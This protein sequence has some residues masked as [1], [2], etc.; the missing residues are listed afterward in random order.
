VASGD[1]GN[2]VA[3]ASAVRSLEFAAQDE[4]TIMA[5]AELTSYLL[6]VTTKTSVLPQYHAEIESSEEYPLRF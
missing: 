4:Q 3:S 2:H 1:A 5:K 6:F